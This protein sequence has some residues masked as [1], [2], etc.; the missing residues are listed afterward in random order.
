MASA[1]LTELIKAVG[2]K[3]ADRLY[4]LVVLEYTSHVRKHLDAAKVEAPEKA[5]EAAF[6]E[7]VLAKM[8]AAPD[9]KLTDVLADEIEGRARG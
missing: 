4:N 1:A 2:E 6:V 5:Q 8:E 7:T 9:R 3:E